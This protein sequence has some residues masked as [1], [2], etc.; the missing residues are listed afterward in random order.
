M[1]LEMRE[2]T[3]R[4]RSA[5]QNID[6]GS[7]E[8]LTV[9]HDLYP[10]RCLEAT[11]NDYKDFCEVKQTQANDD[12]SVIDVDINPEYKEESVQ[13]LREFLNYLLNL[14]IRD[15]FERETEQI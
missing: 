6:S 9:W 7:I 3:K 2:I 10:Q 12:F 8:Q 4:I 1:N 11:V 13:I 5:F 15:F 14:S